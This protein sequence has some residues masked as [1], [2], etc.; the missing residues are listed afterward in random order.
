MNLL[1][2]Y[3]ELYYYAIDVEK[4]YVEFLFSRKQLIEN[5]FMLRNNRFSTEIRV[6]FENSP[7]IKVFFL[8]DSVASRAKVAVETLNCVKNVNITLSTSKAHP[9][10]TLTVYPKPMVD[11]KICEKEIIEELNRF[12][13]NIIMG[14]MQPRNEAFFRGIEN[15]ILETLDKALTSIIV[16]VAWF[17]NPR[18]RDKLIEKQA[19]GIDVKVIIYKDGVNHSKGV[20]LSGLNHKEFR[21]EKGGVMHEKFCVV[22][23]V[24]TI[25]GSY[26]WTLNAENKND[27][28]ATFHIEDYKFASKYSKRFNEIWK[29][30]E[31]II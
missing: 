19:E 2:K 7:Y 26:N 6:P 29:R 31:T 13:S 9:G 18:L 14:N 22:D 27:E 1:K 21:G 15:Q 17:T 5:R 11:A 10:N 8:D 4:Q 25:C 20:D 24:H 30:D 12:F 28:D 23:N 3:M 16:C